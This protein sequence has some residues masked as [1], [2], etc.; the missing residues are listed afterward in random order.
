MIGRPGLLQNRIFVVVGMRRGE[1]ST[2]KVQVVLLLAM[3]GQ[4]LTGNLASRNSAAVG[5]HCEKQGI[6]RAT[7]LKHIQHL[8]RSF[9]HKGNR[10][11]LDA[12]HLWR[13][14]SLIC[15]RNS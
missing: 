3:V 11:H 12:D 1:V 6:Y 2:V 14:G 5:E 8:F 4:R 9:I 10:A 7:F 15:S 13:D